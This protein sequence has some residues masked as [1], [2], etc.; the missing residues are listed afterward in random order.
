MN[1]NPNSLYYWMA[2]TYSDNKTPTNKV[3][4]MN[5]GGFRSGKTCD[6]AD[7]IYTFCDHNR[8]AEMPLEIGVFRNTLKDCR[9]K[10][11]D[12]DF[13]KQLQRN[14][15][16]HVASI[17]D[18]NQSPKVT[19]WGNKISFQGLDEMTEAPTF[20]IVFINE[21]LEIN[22]E[23]KIRGLYMRCTMLFIGDWNPKYTHHWIFDWEGRPNVFFSKTTYKNNKHL[24][25]EIRT[26]IEATSPWH[27]DDLH[28]PEDERRPHEE[29]I[30]NKTADRW[31][32]LVYGMGIRA[33]HEGLVYPIVTY[34]DE[35]PPDIE[36]IA[37]GLDFGE[38][39]A[40][41]FVKCGVR[42][43]GKG[44]RDDLYLMKL[45]YTPTKNSFEVIELIEVLAANGLYDKRKII[46][47][48]N[49]QPGWVSDMKYSGLLCM[50]TVKYP[51]SREYWQSFIGS[52]NIHIV[53]DVEF[54]IEQENFCYKV[55]DGITLSETVKKYDHL[56]SAAGY[57]CVG[58]FRK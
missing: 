41:A 14:G 36:E 56:W 47:C 46:H 30:K 39:A 50:P 40:S 4:I 20:D 9:E 57:G 7:L 6:T 52:F 1:I 2:K 3:T 18:E 53:K 10:T 51:G 8:Y 26:E 49:N 16:Y 33:S 19:L 58:Q 44:V 28:L 38:T 22:N 48:D 37:Y 13:K 17:R 35:F 5:E 11:Y 34:I 21:M 54:Q 23:E 45:F 27:F 55:V 42:R 31:Y 43:N 25:P 32:F 24:F 12:K 29:N 15:L